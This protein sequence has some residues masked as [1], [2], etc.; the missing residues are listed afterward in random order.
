[1]NC[2]LLWAA[3]EK[4]EGLPCVLR[5]R[6]N[7]ARALES[8]GGGGV[9]AFGGGRGIRCKHRHSNKI[10]VLQT[11]GGMRKKSRLPARRLAE[12][13]QDV[14]QDDLGGDIEQS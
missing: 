6:G 1:M 10:N 9:G 3:L 12:R 4:A 5:E 14:I 13:K 2:C 8:V 11:G 7:R